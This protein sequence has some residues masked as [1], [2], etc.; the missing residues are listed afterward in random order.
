[1]NTGIQDSHNLGWKLALV[2]TGAAPES[3]LDSYEAERRPVAQAIARSGDDAEARAAQLDP[4]ARQSLIQFL[5]T[6]EGRAAA[7]MA[8]AEIAFGY[9]QSPIVGEVLDTRTVTRGTQVGFRIGDAA[10][11]QRRNRTFRLHELVGVPGHT[12]FVMLGEADFAAVGDGLALAS[13]AAE[14]YRPHVQAYVVTRNAPTGEDDPNELLCDPAGALHERLGAEQPCLCLVRPDGHL[15]FRGAP[16]SLDSLQA[17][18]RHIF[19]SG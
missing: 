12:L 3:L 10:P 15:G 19:R 2:V 9:D 1:M 6:P 8:E 13:A 4:T 18:L 7:A 17:H 11:L 5:T 14:R 16:P